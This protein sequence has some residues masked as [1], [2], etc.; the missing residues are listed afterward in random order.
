MKLFHSIFLN[1]IFIKIGHVKCI[2][3]VKFIWS[4][5]LYKIKIERVRTKK[6]RA[7]EWLHIFIEIYVPTEWSLLIKSSY[8]NC[9]DIK[10]HDIMTGFLFYSSQHC[11]T[12][13]GARFNLFAR[14]FSVT[15]II[16]N[17]FFK[18]FSIGIKSTM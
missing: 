18:I 1:F 5:N 2:I 15:F 9:I 17:F 10:C 4:Y 14:L 11:T 13:W 7:S 16:S 8:W 6:H 12:M 3:E